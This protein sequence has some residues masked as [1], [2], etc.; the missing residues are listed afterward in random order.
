[1][2]DVCKDE[3][4]FIGLDDCKITP[5]GGSATDLPG[6]QSMSANPGIWHTL[7]RGD[8]IVIAQDSGFNGEC[9]I[10]LVN[11]ILPL[12]LLATLLG[13]TATESGATPAVVR[14]MEINAA[15]KFVEFKLEFQC[16][17]VHS[18]QSTLTL[19][20]DVHVVFPKC[21]I[22]TF[23]NIAM[24]DFEFKPFS[25]QA[26]CVSDPTDTDGLMFKIVTNETAVAIV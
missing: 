16:K 24:G 10:D 9:P 18:T 25:F 4:T 22:K 5:V 20:G 2:P 17:R 21:R 1:M 12:K 11:A 8:N 14:T 15:G 19:P 13:T 7:L 26:H 3:I 6:I 23:P